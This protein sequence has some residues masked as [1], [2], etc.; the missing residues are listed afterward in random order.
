MQSRRVEFDNRD[1]DQA[2]NSN[3]SSSFEEYQGCKQWQDGRGKTSKR[4]RSDDHD[5]PDC[6]KISSTGMKKGGVSTCLGDIKGWGRLKS[7]IIVGI[8]T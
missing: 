5:D 3:S 7:G 6:G 1:G 2:H 8:F 4:A